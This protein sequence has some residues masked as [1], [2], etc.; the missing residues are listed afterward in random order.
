MVRWASIFGMLLLVS[1]QSAADPDQIGTSTQPPAA[2]SGPSAVA[3]DPSAQVEELAFAYW[4][5]FNA[6][7]A[8]RVLSYLEETYRVARAEKIR[9]EIDQLGTF[10][11]TLGIEAE[12]APVLL[13]SD[14]AELYIKLKEP[15]GTRRILMAFERIE[16]DWV[17]TSAEETG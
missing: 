17:I 7:D 13:S 16:G 6:Y 9:A 8:D 2:T 11:V 15:L 4:E 14:S 5:A 3:D 1:C 12:G 10:G